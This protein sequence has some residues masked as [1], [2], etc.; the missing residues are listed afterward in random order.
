[1]KYFYSMIAKAFIPVFVLSLVFFV[2]I[3]EL[4][5]LFGSIWRYLN[6]D[7]PVTDIL[8]VSLFYMPKCIN[9]SIPIAMLF[10]I[11]FSLGTFYSN[12]ELIAVFGSG[13]SLYR[14]IVPY[15]LFGLLFSGFMLFFEERVVIDTF[16]KKNDLARE[17]L[18]EQNTYSNTNVTVLSRNNS[19]VYHADY[20]NDTTKSLNGVI[21]IGRKDSGEF[22]FR[23]DA[24]N[25]KWDNGSWRMSECRVFYPDENSGF[26]TEEK[27]INYTRS[28]LDEEPK[29]FKKNMRN[30]EEMKLYEAREW[31]TSLKKAGLPHR[32]ALTDYYKRIS[33]SL[34]PL[35]VSLVACA[36]GGRFKKN[37]LLL[38]LL[39]SLIISVFYYVLQMVLV[40]FAKLGIIQP[41]PGAWGTFVIF[42]FISFF[43]FK[44]ART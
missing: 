18:R 43:L 38:S 17:L 13:I 33:F 22:L 1:M 36:I 37:I 15:L 24:L 32:A 34:T 40:L 3:L 19:I 30:V 44:M 5:D 25:A 12:N 8:T 29:T 9:F 4:V 11:S 23:I 41:L 14:F 28:T 26:I 16:Q 6:Y 39:L 7:V 27:K 2:L 21:I 42:L 20:Y 10:A 35:I 31:I